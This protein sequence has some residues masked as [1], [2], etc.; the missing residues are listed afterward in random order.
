M[1]GLP[2]AALAMWSCAR[3]ENRKKVGG[4]MVSAALTSFL[5]GITE[6]IEFSFLFVAPVLYAIHAIMAGVAYST[7][8]LLGIKH[9]MTFSHG[10]IDF[11][12]LYSRS[13]HAAWFFVIGPLWAA[14]YFVVFRAAIRRFDLKTPGREVEE[15]GNEGDVAGGEGDELAGRLVAAFGGRGNIRT[16]DACITRLRVEVADVGRASQERLKALGATGVVVVGSNVQAI[17]GP[18]SENLKTDMEA[19]LRSGAP[20]TEG[21]GEATASTA[22]AGHG[23]GAA[24]TTDEAGPAPA[25]RVGDLLHALGGAG[26]V[27]SV[28]AVA[29][30]RLRVVLN[31]GHV[32]ESALLAAGARGVMVLPGRVVHVIVG[33]GAGAAAREMQQMLRR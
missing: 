1:W 26:N 29:E 3:P 8:I 25:A 6:P 22:L 17:F 7:C 28:A 12:L 33:L 27:A 11:V 13:T 31:D 9:G 4:I 5:T 23:A 24:A 21:I 16:L 19:W 10:L 14:L 32:D 20:R 30:T 15:I 18:R 2:A